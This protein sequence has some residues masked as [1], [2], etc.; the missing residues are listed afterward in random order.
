MDF[1]CHLC[2][3]DA[4]PA[5]ERFDQACRTSCSFRMC[6]ACAVKYFKA[7]LWD[8]HKMGCVCPACPTP[9]HRHEMEMQCRLL[10]DEG[11][12]VSYLKRMRFG[13]FPRNR[14][15]VVCPY[16][17]CG[18]VHDVAANKSITCDQC[19]GVFCVECREPHSNRISCKRYEKK[20]RKRDPSMHTSMKLLK[21]SDTIKPCPTCNWPIEK[22]QGCNSMTCIN[23]QTIFCFACGLHEHPPSGCPR[24]DAGSLQQTRQKHQSFFARLR[25]RFG[26][27]PPPQPRSGPGRYRDERWYVEQERLLRTGRHPSQQVSG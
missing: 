19:N 23:C 9:I 7:E 13:N 10:H 18:V 24:R 21:D 3:D 5:T 6:K 27:P 25:A 8:N 20:M 14:R 12:Y 16:A 22:N 11:W 15:V 2:C 26:G 4:V 17:D 1:E